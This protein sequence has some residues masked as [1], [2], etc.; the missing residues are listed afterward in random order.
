MLLLLQ[1]GVKPV[2]VNFL[3]GVNATANQNQRGQAASVLPP[4]DVMGVTMLSNWNNAGA[5]NFAAT[6][7][8]GTISNVFDSKGDLT[9]VSMT[10]SANNA[11]SSVVGDEIA[12]HFRI[13]DGA[14]TAGAL[15][16]ETFQ[17]EDAIFYGGAFDLAGDVDARSGVAR[18]D[19]LFGNVV[20]GASGTITIAGDPEDTQASIAESQLTEQLN[21]QSNSQ[22]NQLIIQSYDLA[23][24]V[25]EFELIAEP[26]ALYKLSEAQDLDFN[27]P[28]TRSLLLLTATVGTLE[29]DAIA[30]R[31]DVSGKARFQA[32][33]NLD[34][35]RNFVRANRWSEQAQNEYTVTSPDGSLVIAL[36]ENAGAMQYQLTRAGSV[37][38][39]WSSISLFDGGGQSVLGW[40]ESS[41]QVEWSS[42]YGQHGQ[43]LDHHKSLT[44]LVNHPNGVNAELQVRVF[45][46]GA[47]MRF[48]VPELSAQ[49][50]LRFRTNYTL[51]STAT[52]Y[53]DRTAETAA[54]VTRAITSSFNGRPV[55]VK[56]GNHF[57]SLL[58]SDLFSADAFGNDSFLPTSANGSSVITDVLTGVT[59]GG[60][61][62]VTPWRVIAAGDNWADILNSKVALNVAARPEGD[63]SWVKPGISVWDWRVNGHLTDDGFRFDETTESYKRMIDFAVA[64][65]FSYFLP[66]AGWYAP[67]VDINEVITYATARNIGVVLYYDHRKTLPGLSS[68]PTIQQV[69]DK[70]VEL[71]AAGIKWGFRP[72]EASFNRQ[73]IAACAEAELLVG[74]HDNPT[75]L[76]GVEITS[77]NAIFWENHHSQLD[78]RTA[79]TPSA[80]VNMALLNNQ[81]GLLD[82]ANGYFAIEELNDPSSRERTVFN[83]NT[84]HSTVAAE[85]ARSIIIYMPFKVLPDAPDEYGRKADLFAVLKDAPSVWDETRYLD[86]AFDS[87]IAVARRTGETWFLAAAT[88]STARTLDIPLDFLEPG[89]QYTA[90]ICRDT[91]SS[92]GFTDPELYEVVQQTLSSTD[93]IQTVLA[94]AGGQTVRFVPQN[95]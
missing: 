75:P 93:T 25:A 57:L 38:V 31:T 18:H 34:K 55:V 43:L 60:K 56:T 89:V 87:H 51:E 92:D 5:V 35:S 79:F 47:A 74:F 52:V 45:D 33:L 10:G 84:F 68:N 58:E 1:A 20:V 86:G 19:E 85:V 6:D 48:T 14:G 9:G 69:V 17:H 30:V 82:M 36:R 66:D 4:S 76:T 11:W 2:N 21:V 28:N 94:R 83:A 91:S 50:S 41:R 29:Y 80:F 8:T 49:Q 16:S 22:P 90:T 77:P 73:A 67:E 81:F 3:S 32:Q 65:G 53:F 37:L 13:H 64:S 54:P 61:S 26:S 7:H 27:S 44:L 23:S 59:L 24:G 62:N 39:Q 71:G 72:N 78:A 40:F 12:G 63:F 95:P 46:D 42:L 15:L 88:N 70:M